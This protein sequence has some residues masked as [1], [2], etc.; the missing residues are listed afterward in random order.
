LGS[1]HRIWFL[2]RDELVLAASVELLA[3]SSLRGG[4]VGGSWRVELAKVAGVGGTV[5]A[6]VEPDGVGHRA[7]SDASLSLV[8]ILGV[9]DAHGPQGSCPVLG[10]GRGVGAVSE[11]LG[12]RA[13]PAD[14]R[15]GCRAPVSD[16]G[17]QRK[18]H[19]QERDL[20]VGAGRDDGGYVGFVSEVELVPPS[21]GGCAF[22]QGDFGVDAVPLLAVRR[23]W[24]RTTASVVRLDVSAVDGDDR[25]Q[26][27]QVLR[28]QAG[29]ND[30]G[31][32]LVQADVHM[33]T[34]RTAVDDFAS[35][36]IGFGV[37]VRDLQTG[38][39]ATDE[40]G[41]ATADAFVV[42]GDPFRDADRVS[43]ARGEVVSGTDDP[44]DDH[45]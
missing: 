9:G 6:T 43:L 8:Q 26:R 28:R 33:G 13:D 3:A 44:R 23:R 17:S 7:G 1:G 19:C 38:G 18:A 25:R 10:L 11:H 24:A 32:D 14:D 15:Q 16:A 40:C 36:G 45:R 31:Q 30:V 4:G 35:H 27:G 2:V 39:R 22:A 29:K 12:D 37:V 34:A 42:E 5:E 20:L 41:H 21:V